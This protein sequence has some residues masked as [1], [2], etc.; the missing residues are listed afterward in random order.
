MITIL[1]WMNTFI[2]VQNIPLS[3]RIYGLSSQSCRPDKA[4]CLVSVFSYSLVLLLYSTYSIQFNSI[5]F[6][7]I[8][9]NSIQFNSIQF[10]S[11][12][13]NSIQ[14]NSIQSNPIQSNPIQSNPIQSNP[15]Q[16][17]PIQFN[18]IQFISKYATIK[19]KQYKYK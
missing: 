4:D 14:F 3:A 12:Q 19:S 17:N 1:I 9:F 16:S 18:S 10:N 6:N 2:Q 5:Q 13:F 8:Q 7:S 11:I 15:I